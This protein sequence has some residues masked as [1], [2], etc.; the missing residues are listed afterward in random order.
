MS[1]PCFDCLWPNSCLLARL[2]TVA[3]PPNALELVPVASG[4]PETVAVPPVGMVELLIVAL[5]EMIG[6]GGDI[7]VGLATG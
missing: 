1:R 2:I 4:K 7:G 3:L 6:Y 5:P